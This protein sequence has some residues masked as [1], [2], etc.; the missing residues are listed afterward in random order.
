[1]SAAVSYLK[2]RKIS[3]AVLLEVSAFTL[4]SYAITLLAKKRAGATCN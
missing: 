2:E 4:A 3:L 1:M